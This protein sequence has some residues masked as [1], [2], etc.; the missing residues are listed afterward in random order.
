MT[1]LTHEQ[2]MTEIKIKTACYLLVICVLLWP[3]FV[4]IPSIFT[5]AVV[6]KEVWEYDRIFASGILGYLFGY[7][8]AGVPKT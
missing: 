2:R 1:E 4:V 3:I 8:S 7:G 6:P 5:N